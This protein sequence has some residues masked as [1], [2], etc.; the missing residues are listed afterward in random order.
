MAWR[1]GSRQIKTSQ[2]KH[3]HHRGR[4]VAA[5]G[6]ARGEH[7]GGRAVWPTGVGRTP[8]EAVLLFTLDHSVT[9]TIVPSP[10]AEMPPPYCKPHT[11]HPRR[12][13]W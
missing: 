1:V 7:G 3:L 9:V 5:H 13:R 6:G 2:E 4:A 8:D 11:E 12:A 10:D